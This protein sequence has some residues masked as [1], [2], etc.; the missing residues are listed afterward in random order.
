M[1]KGS[2]KEEY[3]SLNLELSQDSVKPNTIIE[4]SFVFMIYDQSYGKHMKHQGKV[5]NYT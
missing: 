3:V 4:A 5:A 2:G 1:V